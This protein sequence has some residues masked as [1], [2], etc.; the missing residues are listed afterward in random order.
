MDA[1]F[2]GFL[3]ANYDDQFKLT[4]VRQYLDGRQGYKS[5]ANGHELDHVM[6]KR[7]VTAAD[8]LND[9]MIS[10]ESSF[11]RGREVPASQR[12]TVCWDSIV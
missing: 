5:A 2:W 4:V 6:V 11:V 8:L 9:R 3:M 12:L 7:W 10:L 1:N